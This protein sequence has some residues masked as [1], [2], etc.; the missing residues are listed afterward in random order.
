[1][2]CNCGRAKVTRTTRVNSASAS[3]RQATPQAT[4]IRSAPAQQVAPLRTSSTG[5]VRR[6]V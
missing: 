5:Q 1:M 4:V 3:T 2:G 6:T